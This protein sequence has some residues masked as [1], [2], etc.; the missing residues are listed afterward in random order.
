[1]K[2]HFQFG[3]STTC[4][5]AKY[6]NSVQKMNFMTLYLAGAAMILFGGL[7]CSFFAPR[8]RS[9]INLAATIIG[10]LCSGAGAVG[11][12]IAAPESALI[13][14]GR[15]GRIFEVTALG[16]F[17]VVLVSCGLTGNAF[18]AAGFFGMRRKLAPLLPIHLML[19][20]IF[21]T[22]MLLLPFITWSN[23]VAFLI[24]WEIM[25]MSAFGAI[26]FDY[27]SNK[28]RSGSFYFLLMMHL[29]V[30]CLICGFMALP[31]SGS[32]TAADYLMPMWLLALGFI[33]KL[34]LVPFHSWFIPTYSAAPAHVASPMSG[35]M[36][37]MGVFGLLTTLGRVNYFC[38]NEILSGSDFIAPVGW[39]LIV[40][41]AASMIGGAYFASI[42]N[43]IRGILAGS[44]LENMGIISLAIG[45]AAIERNPEISNLALL[46]ALIHSFNHSNFKPLLFYVCGMVEHV[47]HTDNIEHL[48]GVAVRHKVLG[49]YALI[50]SLSIAALPPLGGFIGEFII[51]KSFLNYCTTAG[52]LLIRIGLAVILA[53]TG[54]LAVFAF[55]RFYAI[56]FQGAPRSAEA[57]ECDRVK[58]PKIMFA[59]AGIPLLFAFIIG[60]LPVLPVK[61]LGG[62]GDFGSTLRQLGE[63]SAVFYL[64]IG[65]VLG[66]YI[67]RKYMQRNYA[68]QVHSTWKCGYE[69][70]CSR[71]EYSG[72]SFTH[73]LCDITPA[74]GEMDENI[75]GISGIYPKNGNIHCH[76]RDRLEGIMVK[77]FLR[78]LHRFLNVFSWVQSGEIR[79][80]ILYGL[81]FLISAIIWVIWS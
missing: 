12:F 69:R 57:A 8:L 49:I 52:E 33:I 32:L 38:G 72:N 71:L 73:P 39:Y 40:A 44:S 62:L 15:G 81:I 60:L 26:L 75:D 30:I 50:G 67:F 31:E 77:F 53:V 78:Y 59:G 54:G 47:T 2:C 70:Y 24:M 58:I 48:G 61:L 13:S 3:Q 66:L 65:F 25:S 51:F 80:Y 64:F 34:G 37:K 1:M 14:I 56:V 35:L 16:T 74:F 10:A 76:F 27:N 28:V 79:H 42:H 20:S 7:L 9:K 5:D 21:F 19:L 11:A 43:K 45:Y 41:G 6:F 46:G 18:Y 17:F 63:F 55:V 23:P 4:N 29:S 36:V 68:K 22:S